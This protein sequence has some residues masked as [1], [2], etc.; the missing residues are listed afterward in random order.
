MLRWKKCMYLTKNKK[1]NK[2]YL[3]KRHT[4]RYASQTSIISCISFPSGWYL[5][6]TSQNT[7]SNFLIVWSCDGI[8]KRMMVISKEDI[9]S[10]FRIVCITFFS[11]SIFVF[12]S[13]FSKGITTT[14]S[15]FFK[16]SFFFPHFKNAQFKTR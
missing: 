16:K 13:P 11:A 14:R 1:R 2:K 9:F 3:K 12:T 7:S 8:T 10:P 5:G 6:T 15:I 4:L